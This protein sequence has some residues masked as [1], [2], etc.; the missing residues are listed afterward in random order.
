MKLSA[1]ILTSPIVRPR[2]RRRMRRD[3]RALLPVLLQGA[4]MAVCGVVFLCG[5]VRVMAAGVIE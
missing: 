1:V 3:M 5:L 4:F 2:A